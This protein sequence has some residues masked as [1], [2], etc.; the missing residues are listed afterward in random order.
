MKAIS[1]RERWYIIDQRIAMK[2]KRWA[3][4]PK[5]LKLQENKFSPHVNMFVY[6]LL[7]GYQCNE[8]L[9]NDFT[10]LHTRILY[11]LACF[12]ECNGERGHQQSRICADIFELMLAN[13]D[14]ELCEIR[15]A[16]IF[17]L[18]RILLHN[19]NDSLMAEK[20]FLSEIKPLINNL[21]YMLENDN[22]QMI[23][24]LVAVCL[25]LISDMVN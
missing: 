19:A 20:W 23:R 3:S 14:H 21:Q 18:S 15:R 6:P 2:T 22:D 7:I 4:K 1:E 12:I 8:Q 17:I 25:K 24:D 11:S 9:L 10:V 5:V 13:F 16:S